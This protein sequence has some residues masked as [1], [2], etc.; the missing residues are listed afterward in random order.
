MMKADREPVRSTD[1]R[2]GSTMKKALSLVLSV[3][4]CFSLLLPA[5]AEDGTQDIPIITVPGTSNTHILNAAGE[6]IVPD[7]FDIGAFLRDR[8]AMEPLLKEFAK[9]MLTHR[10]QKY[11]DMLVAALSPIWAPAAFDGNGE[12]QHGDRTTWTWTPASVSKKISGFREGDYYYRYDWR[13]DPLETARDLDAYIDAVL[14]ATGAEK[15]ALVGRC[16]GACVVS[17]YLTAYG[18]EKVDT[19]IMYMPMVTGVETEEAL[20]TGSIRLN[21]DTVRMYGEYWLNEEKPVSDS[22]LNEFLAALI[23]VVYYSGGVHVTAFALEKLIGEFKDLILPPLIR[24]GYGTYPGYWAMIGQE[25]YAEAKAYVLGGAEGEYAGLIEKI[26]RYHETVQVPLYETLD[27]LQTEGM[28]LNII[29][30]YGV[31][32]YPYFEGS[33][34][35]TDSSNSLTRQSFGATTSTI[36]TV[37]PESYLAERRD[38]GFGVYLSPDGKVDASTCRYPDQTWFFKDV[39]H[40]EMDATISALMTKCAEATAQLTVFDDPAFPQFMHKDASGQVVPLTADDPSDRKWERATPFAALR[41]LIKAFF[42][43]VKQAFAG[44]GKK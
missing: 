4:L 34:Y 25:R 26:D 16:Y 19:C 7:D 23:P 39:K 17:A 41:R 43:L 36:N 35:L 18:C 33:D 40:L 20:F 5:F 28:K 30:K 2:R 32:T 8:A 42:A 37:L 9:A 3:C 12:P 13:M 38:A 11:A 14:A 29:T 15:V 21:A 44:I 22:V 24:A 6:T 1:V 31:P 10:W 27:A